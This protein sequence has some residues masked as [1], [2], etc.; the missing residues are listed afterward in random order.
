M[1][2]KL[3]SLVLVVVMCACNSYPSPEKEEIEVLVDGWAEKMKVD[4]NAYN[5]LLLPGSGRVIICDLNISGDIRK[6]LCDRKTK[7]CEL[8]KNCN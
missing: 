4:L 6:I 2:R 1:I 7:R 5:C 8:H 3:S